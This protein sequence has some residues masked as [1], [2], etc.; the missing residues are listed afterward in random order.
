MG[1]GSTAA[2]LVEQDDSVAPWV[3]E[4]PMRRPA[5]RTG[6]AMQ[7]QGGHAVGISALLDMKLMAIADREAEHIVGLD[8]WKKDIGHE[9]PTCWAE[10]DDQWILTRT[11]ADYPSTEQGLPDI[12]KLSPAGSIGWIAPVPTDFKHQDPANQARRQPSGK[13][14]RGSSPRYLP[15]S[16]VTSSDN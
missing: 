6:A 1:C 12:I 3:E 5:T 7:K 14:A 4:P 13:D 2:A 9:K 16:S 8:R 10:N 11:R 15:V